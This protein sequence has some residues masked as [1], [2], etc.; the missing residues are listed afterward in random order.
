MCLFKEIQRDESISEPIYFVNTTLRFSVSLL[1]SQ[2]YC[3][4]VTHIFTIL[5]FATPFSAAGV[6]VDRACG[7]LYGGDRSVRQLILIHYVGWMFLFSELDIL[8]YKIK[9]LLWITLPCK[10]SLDYL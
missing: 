9:N 3:Q 2:I 8:Q 1:Q 5:L 4:E 6:G 10:H 7:P